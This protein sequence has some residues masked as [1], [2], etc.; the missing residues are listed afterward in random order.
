MTDIPLLLTYGLKDAS[1]FGSSFF[2]SFDV[3]QLQ[4]YFINTAST[5][6]SQHPE[7]RNA[8]FYLFRIKDCFSLKNIFFVFQAN[9]IC[10]NWSHWRSRLTI[11]LESPYSKFGILQKLHYFF[12]LLLKDCYF[13]LFYSLLAGSFSF[14]SHFNING[15]GT[16]T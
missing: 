7:T 14:G 16:S 5:L 11:K 3:L 8:N 9:C 6:D 4:F 13:L 15:I 1:F 12:S 10:N 2:Q